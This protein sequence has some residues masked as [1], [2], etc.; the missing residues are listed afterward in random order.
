MPI[1]VFFPTTVMIPFKKNMTK[2]RC[3]RTRQWHQVLS[4][5]PRPL[6]CC[7]LGTWPWY[8]LH[9]SWCNK[10]FCRLE[11][12]ERC[13]MRGV[14]CWF[15]FASYIAYE[16]FGNPFTAFTTENPEFK[17]AILFECLFVRKIQ[18]HPPKHHILYMKKGWVMKTSHQFW[19]IISHQ[20]TSQVANPLENFCEGRL[21]RIIS[22]TQANIMN[23]SPKIQKGPLFES[24]MIRFL[25]RRLV[26]DYPPWHKHGTW[27]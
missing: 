19:G 2:S 1:M 25:S 4:Q 20:I 11:L 17:M 23:H 5:K 22:S 16:Y 8:P 12:S 10:K 27:K 7:V 6:G 9:V 3:F 15:L 14:G 24:M 21:V 13:G 26:G 18:V